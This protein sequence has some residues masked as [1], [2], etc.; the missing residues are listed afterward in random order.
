MSSQVLG[1]SLSR[2]DQLTVNRAP[3]LQT[4]IVSVHNLDSLD[5][6]SLQP[7]VNVNYHEQSFS[8]RVMTEGET[9]AELAEFDLQQFGAMLVSLMDKDEYSK[10][11]CIAS[12]SIPAFH[13][14]T[15]TKKTDLYLLLVLLEGSDDENQQPETFTEGLLLPGPDPA[16]PYIHLQILCVDE[17]ALKELKVTCKRHFIKSTAVDTFTQYEM[18]VT[19]GDGCSWRVSVRYST[20]YRLKL[21][22]GRVFPEI[23]A[24]RFPERTYM[25][26]LSSLCPGLSRFNE[27]RLLARQRGI[28]DFLN[29]V[30][31]KPKFES[32]QL[33]ELLQVPAATRTDRSS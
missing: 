32:D 17:E 14:L 9:Y 3:Y 10:D 26:C 8:T 7:Y 4:T 12:C 16:K 31:H 6:G 30:L 22:V 20:V 5:A 21:S 28:E 2:D 23:A 18:E 11:N 27:E 24:F 19:R 29:L 25:E 33:M 13:L 1:N 15:W